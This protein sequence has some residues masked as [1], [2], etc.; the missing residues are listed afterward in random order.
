[1][2]LLTAVVESVDTQT[3][4]LRSC[5]C[6]LPVVPLHYVVCNRVVANTTGTRRSLSCSG[7]SARDRVGSVTSLQCLP[8]S[9]S[10][11]QRNLLSKVYNATAITLNLEYISHIALD[12]THVLSH[13][14]RPNTNRFPSLMKFYQL[15]L[16]TGSPHEPFSRFLQLS[17][18]G[19][20]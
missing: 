1:M 2:K 12:P 4:R 13:K 7:Y 15:T 19:K 3:V 6:R 17:Y 5:P 14:A 10:Q 18:N 8:F 20:V 16:D 11:A 9:I